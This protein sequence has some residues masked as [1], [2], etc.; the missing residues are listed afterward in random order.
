MKEPFLLT[1]LQKNFQDKLPLIGIGWD[2][3]ILQLRAQIVK[4]HTHVEVVEHV[5]SDTGS[6]TEETG[7]AVGSRGRLESA[8]S[9]RTPGADGDARHAELALKTEPPG[10]EHGSRL[11][12]EIKTGAQGQIQSPKKPATCN[13]LGGYAE[14][15]P[16]VVAAHE[17]AQ[18]RRDDETVGVPNIVDELRVG[19]G[20]VG[21]APGYPACVRYGPSGRFAGLVCDVS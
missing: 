19:L 3:L 18:R 17:H 12:F 13:V 10:E 16:R 14:R 11:A 9:A 4:A 7:L 5:P 1:C 21:V 15:G 20:V 6:S 8:E 2:G